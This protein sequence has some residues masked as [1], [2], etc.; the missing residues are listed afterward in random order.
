MPDSNR[1]KFFKEILSFGAIA[2]LIV[3]PI[4]LF[5]AQPFIVSGT[6]MYPTFDN[7]EYLI[8]DEL[9]Y[10]FEDPKRGD[11][12]VLRYPNDPS[13]DFIKRVVGLPGESVY[14]GAD[15]VEIGSPDGT[16]MTVPEPYVVNHGNGGSQSV[17]LG[18]DEY[19]V[20]GDNRPASSDS[21]SWGI[22]PRENII[23]RAL[24]RLLPFSRADLFP[25]SLN[26]FK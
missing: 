26:S 10:R 3:L 23:G 22:L 18:T 17:T 11:V 25:G 4:R 2:L 24:L 13:K 9:T 19:F 5:V 21:R 16:R 8:V 14:I 6:S 7:G 20:L 15:R 12:I 1:E